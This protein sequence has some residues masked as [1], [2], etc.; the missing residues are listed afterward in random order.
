MQ[1]VGARGTGKTTFLRLLLETADIS[2][3]AT[4]DQRSSLESFLAHKPRPTSAIKT[5][6]IEIMD[7][8]SENMLL[9]VIDTPGLEF[10]AGKELV[11]EQQI[12]SLVREIE[13]RYAD[14][15]IE[16]SKV[17]RTSKGDGHVHLLALPLKTSCRPLTLA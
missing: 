3:S 1:V 6:S 4:L 14:T 17:I 10:G 12:N 5:L 11:L 9:S 8:P 7:S 2:P 15:M 16:E 13:G